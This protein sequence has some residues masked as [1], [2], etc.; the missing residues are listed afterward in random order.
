MQE[1]RVR[2]LDR[3]DSLE[4]EMTTHSSILAWKMPWTE[5]PDGQ[6]SM[7]WQKLDRLSMPTPPC[8]ILELVRQ[9]LQNCK[10]QK[11]ARVGDLCLKPAGPGATAAQIKKQRLE[12][13]SRSSRPV[14]EAGGWV[15]IPCLVQFYVLLMREVQG[16]HKQVDKVALQA[17]G[18]KIFSHNLADKI[19]ACASPA[20]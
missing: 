15:T 1:M 5:E 12:S 13:G 17:F 6:Q 4:K 3:E 10:W 19:L 11:V 16:R 20:V 7:G 9:K 18:V 8:I 2:S 14:G